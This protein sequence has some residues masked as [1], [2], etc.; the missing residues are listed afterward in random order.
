MRI[1]LKLAQKFSRPPQ[2]PADNGSRIECFAAQQA[3]SDQPGYPL[4]ELVLPART[5]RLIWSVV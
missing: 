5:M 4:V 1:S 3:R 2:G